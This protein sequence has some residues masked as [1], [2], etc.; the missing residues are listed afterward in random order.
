MTDLLAIVVFFLAILLG[1]V[2]VYC[3]AGHLL[4][5]RNEEDK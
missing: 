3:V 2:V 5:R 1:G 4:D